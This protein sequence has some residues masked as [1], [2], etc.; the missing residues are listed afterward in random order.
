MKKSI[1]MLSA[2]LALVVSG[3][4]LQGCSSEF[5]DFATEEYGYYTEEEITEI[6]AIVAKYGAN[7]SINKNYYGVKLSLQEFEDEIKTLSSLMGEYKIITKK[8]A[9]GVITYTNKKIGEERHHSKTRSI[10]KGSWS[11]SNYLDM[12]AVE[13]SITWDKSNSDHRN[14]LSGEAE[15]EGMFNNSS[16]IDCS[17]LGSEAISFSGDVS[18]S[19]S[20]AATYKIDVSDGEV[21]TKTNTGEF[22]LSWA[23]AF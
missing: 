9:K 21:N 11:K 23:C 3:F 12:Y 20:Y 4:C 15:I 16:D 14:Q 19:N 13:V 1:L 22:T 10:E 2:L 18:A 17:F 7:V 5:D 6:K 8:D